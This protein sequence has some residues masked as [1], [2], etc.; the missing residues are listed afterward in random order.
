MSMISGIASMK[1]PDDIGLQRIVSIGPVVRES[2]PVGKPLANRIM[3]STS[4]SRDR[5]ATPPGWLAQTLWNTDMTRPEPELLWQLDPGVTGR[6]E[7]GHLWSESTRP[8]L[9]LVRGR[10][11]SLNQPSAT[12]SQRLVERDVSV[13]GGLLSGDRR[14][15]A[16]S[17]RCQDNRT[18]GSQAWPASPDWSA[19]ALIRARARVVR[20]A[21]CIPRP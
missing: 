11:V 3:N 13:L 16:L 6:S 20:G 15:P 5:A 7:L 17:D 12:A 14:W 9:V 21:T 2:F 10:H 18:S 4:L 19:R 1:R 8:L